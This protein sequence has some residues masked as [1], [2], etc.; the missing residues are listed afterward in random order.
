MV[1]HHLTGRGPLQKFLFS[2]NRSIYRSGGVVNPKSATTLPRHARGAEDAMEP[3]MLD[4]SDLRALR[5]K[6]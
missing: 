1:I 5:G 6:I 3:P 2:K 4:L